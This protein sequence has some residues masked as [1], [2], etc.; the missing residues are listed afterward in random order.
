MA[1]YEE[2]ITRGYTP[3]GA[4]QLIHEDQK[5]ERLNRCA[6]HGR[7]GNVSCQFC[8]ISMYHQGIG[9]TCEV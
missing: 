4:R 2:L 1:T 5:R 8:S 9:F 7:N 3:W 6:R